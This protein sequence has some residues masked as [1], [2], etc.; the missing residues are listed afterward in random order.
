LSGYVNAVGSVLAGTAASV[1]A[2]DAEAALIERCKAG[3]RMAFDELISGHQERVLNTAYRLMGNYE[4]ALDLTQEVFLNCFRKIGSFKGDSALSTWLYRITVN[5]A[6]NRWKYQQSRGMN[7]MHSLDAPM[8]SEDEER[9][10]QVP[11]V[12]PTPRK[13]ASDREAMSFMESQIQRLNGEHREVLVLR[14]LEELSY[15]DIAEILR[16]SLG[17]VKSRIHRARNELRDMMQDYL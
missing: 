15:E 11:D 8:N 3:D 10:K 5:T 7:K 14:Y 17:T 13:V 2:L 16:I 1:G 4:E 9:V 12:Q 6:K